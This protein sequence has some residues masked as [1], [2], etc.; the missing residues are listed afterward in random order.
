MAIS[1]GF[2]IG[3]LTTIWAWFG[4][5][6]SHRVTVALAIVGGPYFLWRGRAA[7][8]IVAWTGLYFSTYAALG[9]SSYQ[10]YYAP[11]TPGMLVL[12]ALGLTALAEGAR[13]LARSAGA[14]DGRRAY[15]AVA[16][17][18]LCVLAILQL[19]VMAQ[20]A[21]RPDQRYAIYR[22]AGEWLRDN[23][24]GDARVG[25]LEVGIIGYYADRAMTDFAGLIQPGLAQA[26]GRTTTYDDLALLAASRSA[27]DYV[28]MLS[29]VLPRFDQD[30]VRRHCSLAHHLDGPDYGF[31]ADLTIYACRR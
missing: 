28:V 20:T 29:G 5:L 26:M 14:G 3:A 11:L 25:A 24:A 7:W 10:W 13:S 1:Q 8:P 18:G 4:H 6:W 17:T 31:P 19:Q 23:T 22:A 30:F 15:A 16:T 12:T 21:S 27:P 9:V 2:A